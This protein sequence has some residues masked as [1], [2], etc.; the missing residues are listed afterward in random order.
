MKL[1]YLEY[2]ESPQKVET[3]KKCFTK[4]ESAALA[5]ATL[6]LKKNHQTDI[7]IIYDMVSRNKHCQAIGLLTKFTKQQIGN[8]VVKLFKT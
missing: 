4:E 1:L 7:D 8:K 3:T 6:P 5:K 2:R